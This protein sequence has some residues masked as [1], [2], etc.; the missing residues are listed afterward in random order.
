MKKWPMVSWFDPIHIMETGVQIV[1]STVLGTR[2]D[3]RW[4]EATVED[5]CFFDYAKTYSGEDFWFD[6]MADTGDGWDSTRAMAKL[7]GKESL[8][9]EGVD[10]KLYR[11]NFLVLGG[12]EVYPCASKEAYKE[13]L[14]APFE[15]AHPPKPQRGE[16]DPPHIYA[17]PGNH[18]WYDG[19]VS[20]MRLFHQDRCISI[21][22]TRQKRSYFALKL[23][24]GWWLWGVDSQLESDI[25]WPQ[26]QYF[27]KMA[28]LMSDHDRLIVCTA[29]PY[30]IYAHLNKNPDLD[31]NLLFLL[32]DK[33][34]GPKHITLYLS[35]AGDLHH[36]RRHQDKSDSNRHKIVSGGGGAFLHPTHKGRVN[37]INVQETEHVE[38]ALRE[39]ATISR[40]PKAGRS[41]ATLIRKFKLRKQFPDE[42]TSRELTWRN[43]LFHY[44]NPWFGLVTAIAYLAL[45]MTIHAQSWWDLWPYSPP[46][47]S[48]V[49]LA[50]GFLGVCVYFCD[51]T[52]PA[53]RWG[54]GLIHGA[55]HVAVATILGVLANQ[56]AGADIH[57]WPS[58]GAHFLALF[59]GG[60]II[61]PLMLGVYLWFSL[62]RLGIHHNEAFSA[63]RNPDYKNFLRMRIKSD[64]SLEVFAIGLPDVKGKPMLI[65]RVK[66]IL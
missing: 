4:M 20:F 27:Q 51:F 61:G 28:D 19:L 31:N 10:E 34:L 63:L 55:A 35:L 49:I 23:P 59:G 32:G 52:K 22:K 9:F 58:L 7:V 48:T 3:I 42:A 16:N 54:W 11:G 13:R 65:E 64:G 21:W 14:V 66:P 39:G 12:D 37:S 43:L 36:Y 45:G 8:T 24:K 17:I 2:S 5:Q 50:L 44:Y 47:G 60:Y 29:E 15:N 46:S 62:N 41:R 30:W 26:V 33:V 53:L 57:N 25:D 6:Y 56:W 1:I 40:M 18:D 38:E